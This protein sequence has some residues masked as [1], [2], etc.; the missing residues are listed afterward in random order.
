[1]QPNPSDYPALA[2]LIVGWFHQDFDIGGETIPEII[3]AFNRSCSQANAK[4]LIAE[5][6]HFIASPGDRIDQEFMQRFRPDIEPTGF[7]PITRAFLE[8][9]RSRLQQGRRQE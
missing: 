8:E 3:D 7:A 9:I 5:T 2:E 1:M 6:S 4:S